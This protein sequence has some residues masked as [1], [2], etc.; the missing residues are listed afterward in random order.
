MKLYCRVV[1]AIKTD[2]FVSHS[3]EEGR[4]LVQSLS[5]LLGWLLSQRLKYMHQIWRCNWV[6]R[7][8]YT[9][10]C[11]HTHWF[12][13][14]LVSQPIDPF[15]TVRA[16]LQDDTLWPEKI[17]CQ[18]LIYFLL[19][20]LQTNTTIIYHF[21]FKN[22]MLLLTWNYIVVQL[23]WKDSL[24]SV[25]F[26]LQVCWQYGFSVMK[27]CLRYIIFLRVWSH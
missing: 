14:M 26:F 20:I 22:T 21:T 10:H 13:C 18:A 27:H 17:F 19:L 8:F 15:L 9:T 1:R 4:A 6:L 25:F 3:T 16:P 12:D 23:I 5:V 24:L 11:Q 2:V 7:D